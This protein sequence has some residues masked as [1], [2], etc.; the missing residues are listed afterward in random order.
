MKM[1][2][3]ETLGEDSLTLP[4]KV[5]AGLA[6][7]DRLKYY[8]TLLQIA[9][10]HADQP[11][12]PASSLKQ[13]RVVAGIGDGSLDRVVAGTHKDGLSYHVPGSRQ[14]MT[15]IAEDARLMAVPADTATRERVERLLDALPRARFSARLRC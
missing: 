10:S 13:E 2:V 15:V 3:I 8:F 4:A 1:R 5:E 11:D 14:L 12:Q 7:N 9:R 6:A